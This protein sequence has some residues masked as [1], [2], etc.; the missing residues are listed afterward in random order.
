MAAARRMRAGDRGRTLRQF[1]RRGPTGWSS[2]YSGSKI[3]R[4]GAKNSVC[5]TLLNH[6]RTSFDSR[7]RTEF[8]REDASLREC[9]R[10]RIAPDGRNFFSDA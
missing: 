2:S 7:Q 8:K 4:D 9:E 6:P 10:Q 3:V 1:S 5:S